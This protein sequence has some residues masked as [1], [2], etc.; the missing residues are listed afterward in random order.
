MEYRRYGH[1]GLNV[2]AIGMGC[3]Q[4]ANSRTEVAVEIVQRALA[5]GITYFDVARA[6]GDAEIKLGLA[7]EAVPRDSIVLSTKT[8]GRTRDDAWRQLNESLE[9]LRTGYLDNCHLHA[10][11]TG[12]DMDQRLGP[13][14]ALEGL[15]EA[16]DQGLIRHLGISSHRSDAAL[17]ALAR[18]D[19]DVVLFPMNVVEREPLDALIPLCLE[20]GVAVTVMKPLA[21]GLLPASLALKWLLN[22]PVASIV[23]GITTLEELE[24][25]A[26]VGHAPHAL[27]D[28]EARQVE[29]VRLGLEHVRC[30]ICAECRPC[31]QEI[32]IELILG[33]DVVYDHYRTMGPDTFGAFPWLPEKLARELP[34]RQAR[35]AQIESC[36]RCGACEARCPH[37]LPVMDM[38]QATLPAMRDIV[39]IFKELQAAG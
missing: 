9:R 19:F 20:Q 13:G 39:R 37:G 21:T 11:R 1:T 26:A 29:E 36:T 8:S 10:I 25:D 32:P 33:T 2:S 14:G 22:Q 23:P 35:I 27:T 5:L 15:L 24:E 18:F 6:Y 31:P 17:A 7:L 12:E 38:L 4:I 3:V 28:G 30:R 34:E 16:R